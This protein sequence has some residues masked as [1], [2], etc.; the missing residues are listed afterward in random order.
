MKPHQFWI[1]WATV[2]LIAAVFWYS[3]YGRP[4]QVLVSQPWPYPPHPAGMSAED[5]GHMIA[6]DSD[7]MMKAVDVAVKDGQK[8]REQGQHTKGKQ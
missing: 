2:V 6:N 3:A 5:Y 1:A 8:R 4:Q 7:Y